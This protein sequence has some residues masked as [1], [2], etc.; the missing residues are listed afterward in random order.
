M[1]LAALPNGT[2][3]QITIDLDSQKIG[4]KRV[5]LFLVAA[6]FVP[7]SE[8]TR[9]AAEA[10]AR[11]GMLA[12]FTGA[13]G[14]DKC[15][16]VPLL[17]PNSLYVLTTSSFVKR[18]PSGGEENEPSRQFFFKTSSL[19]PPKLAPY[20]LATFP[21]TG[22]HYH[23]FGLAPG[24][25]LAS[26]DIL[27]ILEKHEAVIGVR[28]SRDADRTA[29][30]SDATDY[31][32]IIDPTELLTP[33]RNGAFDDNPELSLQLQAL[34][35]ELRRG[36]P[37]LSAQYIS[38][39][40]DSLGCTN[41]ALDCARAVWV[42]FAADLKPLSGYH[43]TLTLLK[44]SDQSPWF[45]PTPNAT[46]ITIAAGESVVGNVG[47]FHEWRFVTSAYRSVVEHA[48]DIVSATQRPK[49]RLMSV[50]APE[51]SDADRSGLGPLI[52]TSGNEEVTLM[53]D[54]AFED[55][56]AE[57]LGERSIR[58]SSTEVTLL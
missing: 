16:E 7:A 35:M 54:K 43:A 30:T 31:R 18:G 21:E 17:E 49:M 58:T 53:A 4:A 20:L 33:I 55:G 12:A 28:L 44:K 47:P 10:A 19:P 22:E 6:S 56:L 9:V 11:Q 2:V 50:G 37:S 52:L 27:R 57:I 36:V 14:D 42:E 24:I 32:T 13:D 26:P 29:G 48:A 23:Y 25:L 15:P 5:R 45:P 8:A 34:R 1:D 3:T 51:P 39:K 40:L 38:H 41:P 46:S